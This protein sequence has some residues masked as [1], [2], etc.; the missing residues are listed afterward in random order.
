MILGGEDFRF[1]ALYRL[2]Q[3]GSCILVE[4]ESGFAQIEGYNE[5]EKCWFPVLELLEMEVT[6]RRCN[7]SNHFRTSVFLQT[8][9]LDCSGGLKE[10]IGTQILRAW[11]K[12]E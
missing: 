9:S 11:R 10:F 3:N 1:A 12:I 7:C 5:S 4:L 2:R 6:V 8:S